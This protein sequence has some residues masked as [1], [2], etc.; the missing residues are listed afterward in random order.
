MFGVELSDHIHHHSLGLVD[1]R[2][3][4][5]DQRAIVVLQLQEGLQHREQKH[6]LANV[7]QLI[8]EILFLVDYP[9]DCSLN[10]VEQL[11]N[12]LQSILDNLYIVF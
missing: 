12:L 4:Q 11:A 5:T 1:L 8:Q 7:F 10:V 6:I 3:A 9:F 2:T